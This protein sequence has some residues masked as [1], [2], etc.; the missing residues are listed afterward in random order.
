MNK[1][2]FYFFKYIIV[3]ISVV[4][5]YFHIQGQN[6]ADSLTLSKIISNILQNHPSVKGATEAINSA[7]AGIGL[8]KSGYFPIVDVSAS[9]ARI[10]PVQELTFPGFG[11][12]Q[13]YPADNYTANLNYFQTIYDFGKTSKNVVLA[14]ENKNLTEQSLE[15][16]KQKLAFSAVIIYYSIVYLQEAIQINKE[17][18]K[19][20]QEHLDF[21]LKK[22]ETGSATQYE[23]L[24]TKVKISYVESM[25][26]DL[27]TNLKNQITELNNLMGQ[28]ENTSL[29]VKKELNIKLPDIPEDSL[30]SFAY[31]HRDEVKIAH[32]KT[33]LAEL[34]YKVIKA[35]DN[36]SLV[37]QVSG[38]GKNGYFPDMNV[39]KP[40]F[41]AGLG[42]KIPIFEGTKTKYNLSQ[43][44]SAVTISAFETDLI[45]KNIASE[46]AENDE[47]LKA[48]LKK[49]EHFNLQL[50]Q[51]LEA[52]QL[53]QM[54]F[55][56]GVITNLDLL[57]AAT[58]ISE[59]S[60]LLLKARIEYIINVFK[61][62][63]SIGE[64]LY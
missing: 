63:V 32:E 47:N 55:K 16:L 19:T 35:Q 52:Y 3:T 30:L 17:Q 62:K 10:G 33:T 53:A 13:L 58:T 31:E 7:N 26:I 54:N 28:P 59:S 5:F 42:L 20:L 56:A 27:Q 45:K 25:G 14:K 38:G 23:I 41:V 34:K 36:P 11:T 15:Q 24:T 64:R 29:T 40:N 49:I 22:N 12:F 8:A 44:K 51:S 39:I 1:L 61:L 37:V 4:F 43:S 18:L 60:L 6:P 48:S 50:S 9:Y 46:V 57:D 21:I 2:N